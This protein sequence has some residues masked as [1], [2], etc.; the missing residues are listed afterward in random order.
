MPNF[1]R[2]GDHF[3]SLSLNLA[4]GGTFSLPNDLETPMTIALFYRGHW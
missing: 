3:P 4:D 1:L 2:P